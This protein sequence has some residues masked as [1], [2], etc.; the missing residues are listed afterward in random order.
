M[1]PDNGLLSPA[2][3]KE[4]VTAAYHLNE[5]KYFAEKVVTTLPHKVSR[6]GLLG[7]IDSLESAIKSRMV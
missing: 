5:S 7:I 2:A 4:G 1:G 3:E 6:S